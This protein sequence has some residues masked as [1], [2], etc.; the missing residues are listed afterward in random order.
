MQIMNR[1]NWTIKVMMLLPM[2]AS[3]FALK[4]ALKINSKKRR[5]KVEEQVSAASFNI[6]IFDTPKFPE[7][8]NRISLQ[9]KPYTTIKY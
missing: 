7:T 2:I 3:P 6:E 1:K 8:T 4:K 9:S 5:I